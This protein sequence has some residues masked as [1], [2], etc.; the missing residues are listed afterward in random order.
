MTGYAASVTG[1]TIAGG[2]EVATPEQVVDA[3]LADDDDCAM[4]M[5]AE[6]EDVGVGYFHERGSTHTHYWT[7]DFAAP[8]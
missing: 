7:Q 8:E 3:W 1:E 2:A 6:F 5:N 4:I